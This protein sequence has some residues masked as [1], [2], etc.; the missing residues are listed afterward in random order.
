MNFGNPPLFP[1]SLTLICINGSDEEIQ[2]NRSADFLLLSDPTAF[3]RE[4][5]ANNKIYQN[6]FESDWLDKNL[7]LRFDWVNKTITD[8]KTNTSTPSWKEGVIHP[9]QLAIEVIETMKDGNHLV[10]DGGNTH[11]GLKLLQIW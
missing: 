6:N 1:Q 11:F 10:F 5:L 3:F 9:L 7:K 8:L 2:L 4:T